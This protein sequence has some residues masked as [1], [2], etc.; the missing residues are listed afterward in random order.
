EMIHRGVVFEERPNEVIDVPVE[1][2]E[3]PS[4]KLW[5]SPRDS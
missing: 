4:S 1:D 5:G 2:E 3:S